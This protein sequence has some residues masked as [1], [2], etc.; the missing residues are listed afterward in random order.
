MRQMLVILLSWACL[1]PAS[2]KVCDES[3]RASPFPVHDADCNVKMQAAANG[4]LSI[5]ISW[6]SAVA[7]AS[8]VQ[9]FIAA[10]FFVLPICTHFYSC[11][12]FVLGCVTDS[13]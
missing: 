8:Y 13:M 12:D 5:A 4:M 10:L 2:A 7:Y 3:W 6:T 11:V 9:T 1:F